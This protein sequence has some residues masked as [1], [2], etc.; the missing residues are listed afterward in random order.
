MRGSSV[1]RRGRHRG[2]VA[3]DGSTAAPGS[4]RSGWGPGRGPAGGT[5]APPGRGIFDA[6]CGCTAAMR[7]GPVPGRGVGQASLRSRVTDIGRGL[8]RC[9]RAARRVGTGSCQVRGCGGHS[10]SPTR[11]TTSVVRSFGRG[12]ASWRAGAARAS[13][14]GVPRQETI[15]PEAA[16]CSRPRARRQ[17]RRPCDSGVSASARRRSSRLRDPRLGRPA[18]GGLLLA[19]A[20]GFLVGLLGFVPDLFGFFPGPAR[21]PRG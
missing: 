8:D 4:Q 2:R 6:W 15:D 11:T 7:V 5:P 20:F 14:G 21:S 10:H 16:P 18:C 13:P 9:R 3:G 17:C 12:S 1:V 19:G